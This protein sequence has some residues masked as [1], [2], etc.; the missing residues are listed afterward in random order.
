MTTSVEEAVAILKIHACSRLFKGYAIESLL[1]AWAIQ[2]INVEL[3]W[4]RL[5]RCKSI[6][7]YDVTKLTSSLVE[8]LRPI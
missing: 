3:Y 6:K 7:F 1:R 5:Y 2:K 8:V 4:H